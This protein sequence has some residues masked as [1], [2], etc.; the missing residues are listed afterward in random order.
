MKE[1][2][3][4]L[5]LYGEAIKSNADVRFVTITYNNK[6]GRV[7]ALKI[8]DA[9]IVNRTAF[10][11]VWRKVSN[12]LGGLAKIEFDGLTNVVDLREPDYYGII[13]TLKNKGILVK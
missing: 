6:L 9:Y 12:T 8:N 2:P 5:R 7:N 10:N 13:I 1:M 4:S 11:R 3:K